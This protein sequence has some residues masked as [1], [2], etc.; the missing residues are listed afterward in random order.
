MPRGTNQSFGALPYEQKVEHYLK[1]NLL[2]A[3]LH[4]KCY[5]KNPKF[6]KFLKES[7]LQ[8][9][10]YEKFTKLAIQERMELYKKICEEIWSLKNF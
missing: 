4:E 10:S 7:G 9:S 6:S 3:S 8:F 2:T 5:K 1:E